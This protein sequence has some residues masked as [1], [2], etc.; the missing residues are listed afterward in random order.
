MT[1]GQAFTNGPRG[2]QGGLLGAAACGERVGELARGVIAGNE[3]GRE[4]AL[5]LL[6]LAG[7]ERYDLFY[8]ANRIKSARFGDT[9]SLC[10]IASVRTG[11]C[12]EDCRFCA[13]SSFYD[14][15]AA[16]ACPGSDDLLAAAKAAE[17]AGTCCFGLVAS[18]RGPTD[19]DIERLG[20][21]IAEI[22]RETGLT[23]CAS[24]GC[25]TERQAE[26][27]FEL[28]VRRYNHNLE[29][30]ERFF[31]EVVTTHSYA[32]RVAT[33]RA[34]GAAGM[35]VCCGGIVGLGETA[36]D[37]VDMAI[38]LRELGVSGVPLNF[39]NP[40]PGTP[41]AGNAVLT[42]MEA[43]GVIAMFRFVLPD[44]QI[45]IAGGRE[46]CLRELQ[47]WMFFA[48]ASSSMIG[49]Y[50]TTLGRDVEMDR[51]MLVD[52]QVGN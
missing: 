29:T 13:Q 31:G 6:G 38:A 26:R 16:A 12:S 36:E 8:W 24:L 20:P 48:G 10:S 32:D 51:Q 40:I 37:R 25:L 15:T 21:V 18:G 4:D 39:L 7:N 27:L 49:N 19:D 50:L 9:V 2:G 44:R 33:V 43:L 3:I 34:A 30:S 22:G 23:C 17:A 52:L 47:S 46:K 5:F 1:A 28:G 11:G 14:A 35:E 41:L 42:P 45:K